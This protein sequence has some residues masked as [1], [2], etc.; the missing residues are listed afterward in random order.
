[1]HHRHNRDVGN[2][3]IAPSS[4]VSGKHVLAFLRASRVSA[5]DFGFYAITLLKKMCGKRNQIL[6]S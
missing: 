1:P 6:L 3:E 4:P 2:P 5:V